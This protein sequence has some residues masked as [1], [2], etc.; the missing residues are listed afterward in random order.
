L[1]ATLALSSP[2]TAP[3]GGAAAPPAAPGFAGFSAAAFIVWLS[4]ESERNLSPSLP[5]IA[6]FINVIQMG[7]AALAPVSFSPS[8]WR[9][10]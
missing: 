9:L 3:V 6:A 4:S 10:S 5:A 2:A 8:D 7:S 1:V